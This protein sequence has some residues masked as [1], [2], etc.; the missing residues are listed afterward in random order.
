MSLSSIPLVRDGNTRLHLIHFDNKKRKIDQQHVY[1]FRVLC[2]IASSLVHTSTVDVTE[3]KWSKQSGWTGAHSLGFRFDEIK[4]F[5]KSSTSS[6]AI[7][8]LMHWA[9]GVQLV[10]AFFADGRPHTVTVCVSL[11][12]LHTV[13]YG[14]CFIKGTPHSHSLCFIKGTPHSHVRSVFY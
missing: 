8:S 1:N 3:M 2:R 11:N 5:N 14:L 10:D 9:E 12:G 7:V 13:T 4:P 6:H